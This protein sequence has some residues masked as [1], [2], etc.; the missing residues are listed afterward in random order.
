MRRS[1]GWV[2]RSSPDGRRQVQVEIFAD[3]I[4]WRFRTPDSEK[5]VDGVPTPENWDELEGKLRQLLQRGHLFDKE[6]SLVRRLR[7]N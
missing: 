4:R 6:L 5:W 2:D 7:P 1:I 3:T